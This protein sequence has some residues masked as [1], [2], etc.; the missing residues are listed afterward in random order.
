MLDCFGL[1]LEYPKRNCLYYTFTTVKAHFFVF[2]KEHQ[3]L[4]LTNSTYATVVE[5]KITV[6]FVCFL[7]IAFTP[8]LVGEIV[9]SGFC[10]EQTHAV[11]SRHDVS[12]KSTEV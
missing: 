5:V 6:L 10:I 9:S 4:A 12:I 7:R 3:L 2:F 1:L 11:S 8:K